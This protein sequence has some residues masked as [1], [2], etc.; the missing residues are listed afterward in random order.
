M[1]DDTVTLALDGDI[2]LEE[3]ARTMGRF[4]EL[5]NALSEEVGSP[6]L[7][8]V[9][10]DL[11]V[12]SALATARS[13][14]DT[15]AAQKV[16]HAY[17]AVGSALE[18]HTPVKVSP[19]VRR[20]ANKLVSIQDKRVRAVRFET[21]EKDSVIPTGQREP[22]RLLS[23]PKSK[24]TT[25]RTVMEGPSGALA[26]IT[27][28][29]SFGAIQGRIQTL[30]NRGTLRFTVYDLLYDKAVGCYI[31]EGREQLLRNVWGR[32]ASIEGLVTRDPI[33]GRPLAVRQVRNISLVQGPPDAP[34]YEDARGAG[35]SLTKLSPEDAIRRVRDA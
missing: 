29:P 3:F 18:N 6:G 15:Q 34:N 30:S 28:S 31:S 14:S 4:V 25:A 26:V 32:L 20:A 24:A 7:D 12:G 27:T 17:T 9:V 1:P 23:P 21:A 16:V 5:V 8:W 35:P 2:P 33:N 10:D 19:R 22:P 11:Q 13:P